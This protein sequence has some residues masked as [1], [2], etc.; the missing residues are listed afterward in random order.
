MRNAIAQNTASEL[1]GSISSSTAMQIL[2]QSALSD[3]APY[4]A[5]QT[6]VRGVPFSSVTMQMRLSAVMRSCSVTRLTPRMPSVFL[7][8][9]R[10]IGSYATRF[11]AL[12][13]LGVTWLKYEA[14]IA[15]LRCVIA[16]TRIG[17]LNS[18]SATWPCDSP[19]GPS[20][21]TFTV[22]R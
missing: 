4:R 9:V 11:I 13:S 20:G 12:D 2:P 17:M 7:R 10:N 22:S 18:S 1:S 19:N 16:V 15:C 3:V 14:T 6:S 21:S 5:R 8:C